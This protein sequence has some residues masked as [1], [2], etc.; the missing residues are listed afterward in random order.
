[1]FTAETTAVTL[2]EACRVTGLDPTGARLLRLGTNA[3][4]RL[5]LPVVVRIA[6]A[7]HIDE[8]RRTVAVARW[9][10][11]VGY[12]A[13]RALKIG[14]PVIVDGAAVTFWEALSDDG[15]AYASVTEVAELLVRLHSL[16]PPV[17]LDLPAFDPFSRIRQRL[18]TNTWLGDGD[19]EFLIDRLDDAEDRYSRLSFTLSEGVIHGDANVGNVLRDQDGKPVVIDLDGFAIGPREWDLI[20]TAIFYDEFGWHTRDEYESFVELYGFDIIQWDGYA[21]L[22]DIRELHMVTWLI[23]NASDSGIIA[24][25]GRKR[26]NSLRTGASRRDWQPY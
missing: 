20:Q 7:G 25:E 19:R 23:Q 22:R 5:R 4:Y 26:I 16:V 2:S 8:L 11:V 13:V 1:M 18:E 3:V 14:Q 12:P 24:D 21:V 10:E 15:D 9:L 17:G 6:R